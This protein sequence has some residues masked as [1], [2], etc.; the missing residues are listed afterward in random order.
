MRCDKCKREMSDDEPAWRLWRSFTLCAGC[1]PDAYFREPQPCARCGRPGAR[2]RHHA[3]H[4]LL[5][6]ALSGVATSAR[7][8]R[9]PNPVDRSDAPD[10][11][12]LS[13][14][15]HE[16]VEPRLG[17]PDDF[18]VHR[19]DQPVDRRIFDRFEDPIPVLDPQ[20]CSMANRFSPCSM[21]GWNGTMISGTVAC[22]SSGEDLG[23]VMSVMTNLDSPASSRTVSV[24]SFVSGLSKLNT[25]G[26]SRVC[27]V[28]RAADLRS[29][30]CPR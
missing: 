24:K 9:A 19:L 22:S 21:I 1:K 3:R 17:R 13:S 14:S 25:M 7:L 27:G 10:L 30:S 6:H 5:R 28:H 8:S 18:R 16:F 11:Q 2:T 12:C 23:L 15:H 29:R 26:G 20:V 4:R